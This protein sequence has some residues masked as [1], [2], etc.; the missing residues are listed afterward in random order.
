ML[1]DPATYIDPLK[2]N[3]TEQTMQRQESTTMTE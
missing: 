3:K 1:I 2:K